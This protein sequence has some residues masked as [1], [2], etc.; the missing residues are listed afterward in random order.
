MALPVRATVVAVLLLGPVLTSTLGA[1]RV[2]GQGDQRALAA[3]VP[4]GGCVFAQM[5]S[6]AVAADLLAPASRDCPAWI[7]GHGVLYTRSVSRPAGRPFYFDG[8]T[9]NAGWQSA[10]LRQLQH[11]DALL[12]TSAPGDNREWSVDNRAYVLA[13]FR[14]ADSVEG[15]GRAATALWLRTSS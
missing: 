7:D 13:Y 3:Q 15:A 10:L 1:A 5:V 2:S 9:E 11:A 6:S 12:L 8:F 4:A 14:F